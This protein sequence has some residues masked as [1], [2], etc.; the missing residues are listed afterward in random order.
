[1]PSCK[2][3]YHLACQEWSGH[4]PD[5]ETHLSVATGWRVR[6]DYASVVQLLLALAK[7]LVNIHVPKWTTK[8]AALSAWRTTCMWPFSV[9]DCICTHCAWQCMPLVCV[10]V[11]LLP[12]S[13]V[14]LIPCMCRICS[15]RSPGLNFIPATLRECGMRPLRVPSIVFGPK[16]WKW[17]LP[18]N[19]QWT[20]DRAVTT[21]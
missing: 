2:L 19:Q 9:P 18:R 15:K 12:S 10:V 7:F 14:L 21:W 13:N 5:N 4:E 16:Q 17:K 8:E 1:M 20:D 3:N 6:H 11:M